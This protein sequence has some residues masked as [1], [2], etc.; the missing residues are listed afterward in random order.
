MINMK[1]KFVWQLHLSLGKLLFFSCSLLW[2]YC[3]LYPRDCDFH[4]QQQQKFKKVL[5][6]RFCHKWHLSLKLMLQLFVE[7]L[8]SLVFGMLVE[9]PA[10]SSS[11]FILRL[12]EGQVYIDKCNDS[13]YCARIMF[14]VVVVFLLKITKFHLF[15][16]GRWPVTCRE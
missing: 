8:F 4:W 15:W 14:F 13:L 6:P 5:Y 3:I 2:P 7:F 10:F 11:K 9:N 1:A 16:V 12:N